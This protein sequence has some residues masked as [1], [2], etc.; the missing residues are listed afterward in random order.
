MLLFL[1]HI[2]KIPNPA[3]L[4]DCP[5]ISLVGFV[6]KLLS[7]ILENRLKRVSP[8]IISPFQGPF[9]NKRQ[10][11]DRILNA[12]ELIHSRKRSRKEG[13]IFKIDLEKAYDMLGRFGFGSKWRGWIWECISSTSF[14]ILVNGSHLSLFIASR[15]LRQGD[16]LSP[17]LFTLVVEVLG[18]LL[19][20][21]KEMRLIEGFEV[22]SNGEAITH[23][24]F[25]DDTILF[26]FA[27]WEEIIVLKRVLRCFQLV[28]GLKINLSKSFL[29]GVGSME[30][31]IALMAR[32]LHCQVSQLPFQHLG[33]P[34]GG[35]P[36]RKAMWTLVIE[37][38]ERKLSKW[39]S[40]CLS[41]G[42]KDCFD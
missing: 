17:F 8:F 35:T 5:P 13:V 22:G 26:T 41:L 20:K 19:S 34:V 1:T 6:Y 23:L 39:K 27:R 4:K 10:I 32:R 11:L 3:E 40:Q 14:S 31:H 21:A 24:Q 36:S 38:F 15:G 28:S 33:M 7:K 42:G 29:V 9:V 37:N 2:P 25:A 16:P 30:D 12:N 18:T